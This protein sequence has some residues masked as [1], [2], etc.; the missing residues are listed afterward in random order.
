[1]NRAIIILWLVSFSATLA[2]AQADD[3]CREY[4]ETPTREI[5]RVNRVAPYVFGRISLKGIAPN[6][7]MPRVTV[8]Y[9]DS[10]QPSTRLV[11]N[12]SGNYCFRRQGAGGLL[13]IEVD[14]I[15]TTRKTVSDIGEP[16]QRED[17]EIH[18][19]NMQQLAAPGV[20]STK[21]NRPPNEKTASLYKKVSEAE[22][23][24]Q[25]GRAIEHVKEI[26][27][28]DPEDFIAWA[29][30]GSLL[31]EKNTLD[32]AEKA[33]KRSL[34]LRPDYNAALLNLGIITAF[35]NKYTEAIEI[36][37]KVLA[38]EPLNGRAYR[39][40]GEAYLQNRQGS[41]GLAALDRALE[42]DPVGMAECHLLKA[43][44][45]DLVGAKNLATREYKQFLEKVPDY[46]EKKK[47]KKY[48]KENPDN[49]T[50]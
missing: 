5:D 41:L 26:V 10:R 20:I 50:Q 47:L 48:I 13:I 15:E 25:P 18:L 38:T 46:T 2:M 4:G 1:M 39:F 21:F 29:K 33:F 23:A 22:S 7:E 14:G 45:F 28:L 31:M 8:I 35:Q 12:R 32:E 40:L 49:A 30:L 19:Q 17:F 3:I 44:L 16:R 9:S 11:L 24:N 27:L 34:E 37:K 42:I 36:F 43:R 6:A